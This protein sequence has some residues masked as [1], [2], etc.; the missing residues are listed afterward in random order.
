MRYNASKWR[1]MVTTLPITLSVLAVKL[2]ILLGIGY[3][4]LVRF[5]DVGVIVTGGMFLI[6]FM[7]AGTMS[8]YKESE[9]VPAE[10]ASILETIEETVRLG[11]Q[12]KPGIDLAVHRRTLLALT[13]CLVSWFKRE[14]HFELVTGRINDLTGIA[15]NL[16]QAG[17][18]PIGSRVSGEQHNLRKLFNRANVIRNTH[19]LSTGYALMQVLTF[20]VIGLLLVA[21]FDSLILAI[22]ITSFIA[23]IFIY[24]IRLIAD[25]DEPFEY[26]PSG[27]VGAADVDLF[28]VLQYRERLAARTGTGS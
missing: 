9:K 17:A 27:R 2:V 10:M 14:C 8:D 20:V 6:G 13:D 12:Y 7:L 24:M 26:D 3:E 18:G 23:Q 21:K 19:F 5:S 4:G 11:S 22:I 1:L 16:E 25:I 15:L 28:P